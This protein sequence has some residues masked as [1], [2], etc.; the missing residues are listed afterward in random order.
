MRENC[1]GN[2]KIRV[3]LALFWL[4]SSISAQVSRWSKKELCASVAHPT[5]ITRFLTSA[6]VGLRMDVNDILIDKILQT[7]HS[8]RARR[9]TRISNFRCREMAKKFNCR[10]PADAV[11]A[12]NFLKHFRST[13]T[14]T[15]LV[16]VSRE[17]QQT[18]TKNYGISNG[19]R[20]FVSFPKSFIPRRM[21]DDHVRQLFY[22]Q[23]KIHLLPTNK[24]LVRN[25]FPGAVTTV[26]N[27]SHQRQ[28]IC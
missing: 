17:S 20:L 12:Q 3:K 1:L 5:R 18:W 22:S 11:R 23:V 19:R 27:K 21:K 16:V 8:R 25:I 13:W 28:T 14:I 26:T 7:P 9:E 24:Y 10:G 4:Y 6:S 2:K 15:S